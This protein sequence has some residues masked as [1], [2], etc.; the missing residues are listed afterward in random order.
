MFLDLAFHT[1][2]HSIL[3]IKLTYYSFWES[4]QDLLH[5]Y[6]TQR[7]QRVLFQSRMSKW[8]VVSIGISQGSIFGPLLFALYVNGLP[9]F[10]SHCLLDLYAN[11]TEIHCSDSDLQMV[12]IVNNQI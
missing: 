6:L 3:C 8:A 12:R 7:Q 5:S 10:V 4:S 2:D 9:S 1:V 11:D